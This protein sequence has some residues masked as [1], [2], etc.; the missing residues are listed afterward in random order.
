[1]GVIFIMYEHF[2]AIL[3]Q[4]NHWQLGSLFVI[5]FVN[6]TQFGALES[7]RLAKIM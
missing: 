6:F 4:N 7:F 3:K 5:L 2:R 1:M